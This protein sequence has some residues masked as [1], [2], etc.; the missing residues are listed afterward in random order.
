MYRFVLISFLF[1]FYSLSAQTIITGSVKDSEN[2]EIPGANITI[3]K[4]NSNT[5]VSFARS[6]ADGSYSLKVNIEADSIEIKAALMNFKTETKVVLNQSQTVDFKLESGSLELTEFVVKAP[7]SRRYG[8]TLIYNVGSYKTDADRTI[9]DVVRKLP[10]IETTADGGIKYQGKSINAY[11]VDGLNLMGGQYGLI[12]ENL[13]VNTAF[14]IEILENHQPIRILDSLTYS[15]RA[16]INIKLKKQTTFSLAMYY[17]I[18]L[19]PLLWDFNLT[20][21][22]FSPGR[23]GLISIQSNNAGYP[24]RQQVADHNLGGFNILPQSELRIPPLIS[25]NI[26]QNKWLDNQSHIGSVNILQK[27]K[28]ETEFRLNSSLSLNEEKQKGSLTKLYNLSGENPI[29]YY[30]ENQNLYSFNNLKVSLELKN[31][32]PNKYFIN[33]LTMDKEWRT[34]KGLFIRELSQYNQN[35]KVGDINLN[36]QFQTIFNIKNTTYNLHSRIGYQNNNQD[37]RINFSSE[38]SLATPLQNYGKSIFTTN[39]YVEFNR[40]IKD[41]VLSFRT[42]ASLRFNQTNTTLEEYPDIIKAKND[43]H[44]NNHAFYISANTRLQSKNRKWFGFLTLPIYYRHLNISQEN[45]RNSFN[46]LSP[47]PQVYIKRNLNDNLSA[48]ANISAMRPSSNFGSLFPEYIMYD[49]MSLEKREAAFREQSF[50]NTGLGLSYN[51]AIK[52]TQFYLNYSHQLRR[53]NLLSEI[54]INPDG[55]NYIEYKKEPGTGKQQIVSFRASKNFIHIKTLPAIRL[56]YMETAQNSIVNGFKNN[57][58][59]SMLSP[60]LSVSFTG[61]SK[62]HVEYDGTYNFSFNAQSQLKQLNQ[63]LNFLFY[64]RRGLLIKPTVEHFKNNFSGGKQN[65]LFL[66]AMI[67]IS[68][69]KIKQ[70]FE[71][72]LSNLF[73]TKHFQTIQVMEYFYS[74]SIYQLRPRQII[75]RGKVN[76]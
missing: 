30:E 47:E 33:N 48:T 4:L 59:T 16:A 37:L 68:V 15:D 61:I 23:Q 6:N 7:P 10:G 54:K 1:G 56:T 55:T 28:N 44:S 35:L 17:G 21:M 70:D 5:I 31:N 27:L 58:K 45:Q 18:G 20:P 2:V 65:Y 46:S 40:K 25:P 36:N 22:I 14:Q 69:P 60:G 71:I 24:I 49:Y 26:S 42:G 57:F 41:I 76:F 62:V 74:E 53:N 72:E 9:G 43:Y 67:R 64:P 8:D 34:D 19:T 52:L 32:S 12:N 75:I 3:S 73:N 13:G 39:N 11:Y 29:S 51:N 50:L 66:D 63:K 38:D